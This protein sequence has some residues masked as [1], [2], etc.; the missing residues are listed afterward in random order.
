MYMVV[1]TTSGA[2][3]CPATTPVSNSNSCVIRATLVVLIC[4]SELNLVPSSVPADV[5]QSV[6]AAGGP[7]CAST[8]ADKD[9]DPSITPA[10]VSSDSDSADNL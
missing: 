3:S 7:D 4:A 9:V 6:P 10:A 1:P 5:V 8:G 2:P